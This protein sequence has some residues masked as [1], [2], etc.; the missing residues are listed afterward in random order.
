MR[1]RRFM[2]WVLALSALACAAC[3]SSD[4][5]APAPGATAPN[6]DARMAWWR[7]ARFGMF[8]HWGLYAI[9]A[10]RYHDQPIP[11]GGEWIMHDA[12]IPVAE[13][14]SYAADFHP[15]HF[16]AD[17]WT[18]LA[19]DTGMKYVVF[20]TKHHDG[21]AMFHTQVDHFNVFDATPFRRD[22]LAELAAACDKQHLKL[23]LYYSHVQD[24]HHPGGYARGGHWDD[25]Q[26]GDF[27][28]YLRTIALPQVTELLQ[29][30]PTAAVLWFDTPEEITT[31]Q[32]QPF[33]DL[34]KQHPAL[35][36]NNRLGGGFAG[37]TETPEQFIP[38]RGFPGRDW[39]TCQTINDTW[40][41]KTDDQH[42][43]SS[44][45]LLRQ[46]IDV[47]SKGG[48]FLL[49]VSPTAEGDIPLEEVDRLH[50]IGAWLAINGDA[51]YGTGPTAFGD[52]AGYLSLK[53]PGHDGI[54]VFKPTWDWRCTTKPNTLYFHMLAPP[55]GGLFQFSRPAAKPISAYLL[56]DPAHTPLSIMDTG[57]KIV[58][59]LPPLAA[60]P[61]PAVLCVSLEPLR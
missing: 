4:V 35:I 18:R 25:A 37:D 20:T 54:P 42:F 14:A 46:L 19:H 58:V 12:K 21:F 5:T 10:G 13:Y 8:I 40:G 27:N 53:E 11:G 7:D 1:S 48:N 52:E 55:V 34:V 9:P 61:L 2:E 51:I 45:E 31:A 6:R 38:P 49:N 32:A 41:Y 36:T 29:A 16:D 44:D 39:E 28:F 30:Y 3:H 57:R 60:T 59:Q 15:T 47:A 26:N 24:W 17:A 22:P 50:A 33:A 23:G 43:K 56:A